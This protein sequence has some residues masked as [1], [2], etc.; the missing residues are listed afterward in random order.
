MQK[1]LV[2]ILFLVT[3]LS[4]VMACTSKSSQKT[5]IKTANTL[6][7]APKWIRNKPKDTDFFF[8]V[9]ASKTFTEDKSYQQRLKVAKLHAKKELGSSIR[10][11]I[12]SLTKIYHEKIEGQDSIKTKHRIK[13]FIKAKT[14]V[15]LKDFEIFNDQDIE[16]VTGK[17]TGGNL[18]VIYSLI[19]SPSDIQTKDKVLFIEDLDEYLY[20][21]DRVMLNLRRSGKLSQIKALLVGW[22]SDMNDNMIPFGKDAYQ[23]I[24]EQMQGTN[25]P[26][27]FGFPAGHLE[28]NLSLILGREIRIKRENVLTLSL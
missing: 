25:V 1:S 16:T 4:F 28:P 19:G 26:V 24:R 2:A 7:E 6:P 18:S 8:G 17:I 9:G 14:D 20:H 11:N 21:I 5:E 22:M 3:A 10:T 12:E 15:L 13:S 27:I 23:I